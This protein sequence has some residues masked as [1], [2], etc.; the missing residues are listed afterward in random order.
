MNHTLADDHSEMDALLE[1]LFAALETV[2]VELIYRKLDFF[3]A[4]LA[5]HIR[6]EHLHLFPSILGALETQ[7][8]E[9]NNLPSLIKAQTAINNLQDDHNFFMREL[10]A[11]IKQ[12]RNLRENNNVA[13]FS[14]QIA[15]VREM[16]VSVRNRLEKHN[17]LE[18]TEVYGWADALLS[19]TERAALSE[20]MQKEITNLSPRFGKSVNT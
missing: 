7:A 19:S 14:K 6:A 3:R 10:L 9:N 8:A 11:A 17:D 2:D 5:M 18:E 13:D 20:R 4:R 12:L 1:E 15:G 16:I